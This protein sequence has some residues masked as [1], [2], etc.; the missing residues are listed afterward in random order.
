M[1]KKPDLV[2]LTGEARRDQITGGVARELALGMKRMD[3]KL[4]RDRPGEEIPAV[5][6]FGTARTAPDAP[7]CRLAHELARLYAKAGFAII[8][9]GGDRGVMSEAN[10]AGKVTL[11][12]GVN[13]NGLPHE[14][15]PNPHQDV[16]LDHLYFEAREMMFEEFSVAFHGLGGGFGTLR[17]MFSVLT[18]I[19]C[20][21]LLPCPV[22]FIDRDP[23]YWGRMVDSLMESQFKRGHISQKDRDLFEVTDDLE[24]VV[25]KVVRF[26]Q[27]RHP[28]RFR[29]L[30]LPGNNKPTISKL[31]QS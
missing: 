9:G 23:Q 18:L 19:Q 22:F 16:S 31:F 29:Q 10:R 20:G 13:I 14:Q 4:R 7:E 12:I 8:T 30:T 1:L 17:E 24:Y 15:Q 6:I 2:G 21:H 3:Q 5:S 27:E 11:S 25:D 28:G 26:C